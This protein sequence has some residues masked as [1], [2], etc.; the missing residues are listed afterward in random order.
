[1]S[2]HVAFFI[3]PDYGHVN[4]TFEV[5]RL[6][7]ERGHRVTYVLS[8][9]YGP[10]VE[11]VGAS[12]LTFP[13]TRRR[14]SAA[15]VDADQ[16]TEL[17]LDILGYTTGEVLPAARAGFAADPPDLI[18][19]EFES[20]VSARIL[21]REWGS[22]TLQFFPYLASNE[23]WSLHAEIFDPDSP[24]VHHGVEE[25]LRVLAE[26][27]PD[28]AAQWAMMAPQDTRNLVLLPRAL[29]PKGETFDERYTFVG[30]CL[31]ATPPAVTW[32]PPSP[33]VAV[34]LVSMGT[35]SNEREH[36]F[37]MCAEAFADGAWHVVMTL[38]RGKRL[39]AGLS[40]PS[41]E[42][43]E[44]LPHLAVL[45]HAAVLVCHGGMGSILEALY[46][47]RPVVVV[48]HT[49]E[50]LVNGRRLQEL[51][52]GRV[53]PPDELDSASLRA[54]VDALAHDPQTLRRVAAMQAAL[55]SGG[56]AAL[57]AD[58]VEQALPATARG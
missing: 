17:G 30:H 40:A 35:E 14:L 47:G 45:P 29:Q 16:I 23:Q 41:V 52:I 34:A 53:L 6:L 42:T 38:G 9:D 4:P 1:M 20:F 28:P 46:F 7:V 13:A 11:A 31:P 12:L 32:S 51:G 18:V 58:V 10:A 2:R 43:H 27:E 50:H 19:Y 55:R 3:F 36:V 44:W 22:A 39:A 15:H 49:P 54:A 5:A 21:A 25:I 26:V 33:D 56:G 48:P 57:A 37:H 24:A 8:P